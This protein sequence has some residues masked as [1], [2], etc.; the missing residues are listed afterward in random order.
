MTELA[1]PDIRIRQANDREV[2]D[3]G[4]Y[5]LYWMIANRR[6]R[7]NFALQRAVQWAH[8]LGQ[9]L[10]VLE[11]LR[12][13]YRWASDRF[14]RFVIDGMRDH[15]AHFAKRKCLYMPYVEP[16]EG[17]GSGLLEALAER[18]SVV[19]T[20][21]FPCFF[22]PRMIAAAA[23]KLEV[24][25][26]AVDSNGLL[27]LRATDKVFARAHDFRRY[28]HKNL[29]EHLEHAPLE[30]PLAR[31]R[32]PVL[33]ALPHGIG[34]RWAPA[35]DDL[36]ESDGIPE[37]LPIDHSIAPVDDRPGGFVAGE[38]RLAGFVAD[39]LERYPDDRNHPQRDGTSGLSP[40]LHFGHVSVHDAW[41]QLVE[42]ED[43]NPTRVDPGKTGNREG[44]WGMGEAAEGFVDELVTWREVGY[45]FASHRHDYDRYSSLPDWAQKTLAEHAKDPREH[46]YTLAQ[47]DRAETH[48][49]LWNA[50]QNQLRRCGRIHNY[51]RMLWG[52]KILHWSES[53][54]K[55]LEIMIE[56]NNRYALDGRNPN[57]YSG[58]FWTLGRYDRAWGPERDV[59]G[60]I[61]YMTS[62][63]TR[64]KFKVGEYVEAFS[65]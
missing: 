12:V 10:I 63:S 56:L 46:R 38:A 37:D 6:P 13:G 21:E 14:H 5:V 15:R 52:K 51:L 31:R 44:F 28:L 25:L 17:A 60:K 39:S 26:E 59:F 24:R 43:W 42:R 36:L 40:Y 62:D 29:V 22:L 35:S 16:R 47:F 27:P 1:V 20:D 3:E 48:D 33:D 50:A 7:H 65:D 2:D 41:A 64:R 54:K 18:A 49:D 53:P 19:V 30:D 8:E 11:P 57:S 61:R 23:K 34:E 55:A 32:I 9:P 4:T 45:N 58:I